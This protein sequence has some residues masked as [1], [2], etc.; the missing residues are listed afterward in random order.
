[1]T[2]LAEDSLVGKEFT[3]PSPEV[4]VIAQIVGTFAVRSCSMV[5]I[6]KLLIRCRDRKD[7]SIT[8]RKMFSRKSIAEASETP[9]TDLSLLTSASDCAYC[10]ERGDTDIPEPESENERLIVMTVFGKAGDRLRA[11]LYQ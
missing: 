10:G 7:P 6:E 1:M 4:P 11:H 3:V 9:R 5:L 2:R 8:T